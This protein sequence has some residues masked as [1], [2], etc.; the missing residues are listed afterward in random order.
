MIEV[1][2]KFRIAQDGQKALMRVL[3]ALPMREPPGKRILADTYYDTCDFACLRRAIF[4]RTRN[5]SHLQIKYH[6]QLDPEHRHCIERVFPWFADLSQV[7]AFNELCARLLPSWREGATI[8]EALSANG[9]RKFVRISNQRIQYA[10]EQMKLC[11][12]HVEGLGDFL[13]VET[14][15]QEEH[16]V[17]QAQKDLHD[18]VARLALPAL[19]PVQVGYVELWLRMHRPRVYE[20]GRYRLVEDE[21]EQGNKRRE[22]ELSGYSNTARDTESYT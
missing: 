20:L 19:Q 7:R 2:L 14:M 1:E 9:L 22:D 13:E 21:R 18:F 17:E 6:E 4:V 10:H 16:Q 3:D 12:D 5:R 15:C 8:E 11:V